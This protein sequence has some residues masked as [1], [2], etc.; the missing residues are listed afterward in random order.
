[1]RAFTFIIGILLTTLIATEVAALGHPSSGYTCTI[2]N[3]YGT[4]I[5]RGKS[6]LAAKENARE[7]CGSKMIDDYIARRGEISPEVEED[8]VLACINLECQ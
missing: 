7:I 1:M 5:G 3:G 8:L 6:Q 4:A 2:A